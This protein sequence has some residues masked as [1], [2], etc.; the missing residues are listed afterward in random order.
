[1]LRLASR[2][3]LVFKCTNMIVIECVCMYACVMYKLSQVKPQLVPRYRLPTDRDGRLSIY[4]RSIVETQ[5]F[6]TRTNNISRLID[7]GQEIRVL[8]PR[9]LDGSMG[10]N[11]RTPALGTW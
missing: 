7:S 1:M 3:S 8:P 2:A 4:Y 11:Q 5:S 6:A 9:D 10:V